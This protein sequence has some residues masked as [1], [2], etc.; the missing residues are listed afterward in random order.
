ML[1]LSWPG[2]AGRL[3]TLIAV[4]LTL[5]HAS[6][7]RADEDADQRL[8]LMNE[9]T[10]FTDVIDAFDDNDLFDINLS[11]G[12]QRTWEEGHIQRQDGGSPVTGAD[13]GLDSRMTDHWNDVASY[14]R[15]INQL[16]FQLDVGIFRDFAAYARLPLILSDDRT[17]TGIG[18]NP[19]QYT[20]DNIPG[21]ASLF[22]PTFRSP[23]R[24]GIDYLAAGLAWSITNQNRDRHVPT[25]MIMAEGQ[26]NLGDPMH[27]CG[28]SVN[29][30]S[31]S[32]QMGGM[33]CQGDAAWRAAGSM[34]PAPG[35]NPGVG[36]GFNFLRIETRTSYR[37]ES[38]EPYAGLAFQIG[39][40]GYSS[41]QF[42]PSGNLQGYYDQLPPI[43]GRFTVGTAIIPWEDR[44]HY[45]RFSI[46]LRLMGDYVSEGH[47]Y[48]PLFDALGSS[49]NPYLATPN[50]EGV[51]LD[52]NDSRYTA[53]C[54]QQPAWCGPGATGGLA[55]VPFYGL[56]D[57]QSHGRFGGTLGL[58]MRAARY[59]RFG[60]SVG[61][62][63][64]PPYALTI[65]TACN[66][67]ISQ[68][69]VADPRVIGQCTGGIINPAHR[70]VI[71]MPGDRFRITGWT[72][73]DIN[74]WVTAMF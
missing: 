3:G 26:F 14:E 60:A 48:S 43:T 45:Q 44:E 12:Y 42:L 66:P 4:L 65:A 51:P 61:F 22:D 47:D 20:T 19:G 52:P 24:S 15:A 30:M 68:T 5:A 27:A 64:S 23:T 72:Q 49:S 63:Y 37:Y 71:D 73:I 29:T 13:S 59:I 56:T 34:G 36:R 2:A 57:V 53:R 10:S 74:V 58:E 39:W 1:R 46:D 70:S 62:L 8:D 54:A 9:P 67:N 41:S 18:S 25:W 55:S 33:Q 40:P 21:G 38:I 17:L 11:V 50:R 35:Q 6:A 69:S 32:G 31:P 7:A 16:N 28:S